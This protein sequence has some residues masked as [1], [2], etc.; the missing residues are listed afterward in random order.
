MRRIAPPLPAASQPS[1]TRIVDRPRAGRLAVQ[2]VE[3]ALPLLEQL[4]ENRLCRS[5]PTCR[6]ARGSSGPL[7][8]GFSACGLLSASA[9]RSSLARFGRRCAS[10]LTGARI[11]SRI[12]VAI[13]SVRYARPAFDD[14][15]GRPARAGPLDDPFGRGD[16]L[17]A[18]APV[19]PLQ[20]G[21]APARELVALEFLQTLLVRVAAEVHPE[22]ENQR[23]VV[24][25][26]LL[27]LRD[28]ARAHRRTRRA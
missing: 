13:V 15:P 18:H 7:R 9:G 11:A 4:A 5:F 20:L 1:N 23:A 17:V 2:P 25:K 27:E 21:D 10:W 28:P 14:R 16:E 8:R 19:L 26:R 22:L 12:A 24:G 6:D 3:P